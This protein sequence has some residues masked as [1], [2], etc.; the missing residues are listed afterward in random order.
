MSFK[1]AVT[2]KVVEPTTWGLTGCAVDVRG[3]KRGLEGK[4]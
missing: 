1:I 3:D 2:M 4:L